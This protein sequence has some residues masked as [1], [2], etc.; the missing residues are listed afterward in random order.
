MGNGPFFNNEV[1]KSKYVWYAVIASLAILLGL[2]QISYVREAL[3][4]IS[5]GIKEWAIILT[6]S[7]SS[8]IIIQ[9]SRYFKLFKQAG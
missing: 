7:A 5:M 6:A 8:V 2:I 3:N 4:I 1:I 9:T